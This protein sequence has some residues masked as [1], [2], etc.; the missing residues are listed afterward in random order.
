MND[1]KLWHS[2]I[3]DR[4]L[5]LIDVDGEP[6]QSVDFLMF[7]LTTV[8]GYVVNYPLCPVFLFF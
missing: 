4:F 1:S 2:F 7:S 3:Q 5:S 8:I 6:A